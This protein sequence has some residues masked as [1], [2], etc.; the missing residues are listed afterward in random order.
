MTRHTGHLPFVSLLYHA[1]FDRHQY[2]ITEKDICIRSYIKTIYLRIFFIPFPS[3]STQFFFCCF[4]CCNSPLEWGKAVHLFHFYHSHVGRY[5]IKHGEYAYMAV[6]LD[7]IFLFSIF[8]SLSLCSYFSEQHWNSFFVHFEMKNRFL[9]IYRKV[10]LR[11]ACFVYINKK[12]SGEWGV[13]V[14][15]SMAS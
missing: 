13:N 2:N 6:V 14:V 8:N 12:E 9:Y 15:A 7:E 3:F 10:S 11:N 5:N 1:C 4:C